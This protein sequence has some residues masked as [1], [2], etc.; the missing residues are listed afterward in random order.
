MV[1]RG[2]RAPLLLKY[3]A[4]EMTA[5]I[6]I[7]IIIIIIIIVV[8]VVVVVMTYPLPQVFQPPTSASTC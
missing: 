2:V 6:V 4:M 8:V 7:I 1:K 3:G 5:I